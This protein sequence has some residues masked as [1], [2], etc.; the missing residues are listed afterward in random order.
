MFLNDEYVSRTSIVLLHEVLHILGLVGLTNEGR[1]FINTNLNVYTGINGIR[2]YKNVLDLNGIDTNNLEDY[3]PI[4]DDFGSGTAANHFEEGLDSNYSTEYRF[5]N[6]VYYPVITNEICT[7]FVDTSNY[8]T[9]L[10]VG[11]LEDLGFTVNYNSSY[12]KNTGNNISIL[13]EPNTN[14]NL[15]VTSEDTSSASSIINL[16]CASCGGNTHL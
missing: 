6:G 7:G 8:L 13:T 1:D 5:I 14:A 12:I 10:T 16:R 3:V 2:E 15:S 9:S 11:L 4:E